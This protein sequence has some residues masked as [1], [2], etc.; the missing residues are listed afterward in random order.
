MK[1]M[2]MPGMDLIDEKG[3]LVGTEELGPTEA[4]RCTGVEAR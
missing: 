3:S 2:R 4:K 1:G